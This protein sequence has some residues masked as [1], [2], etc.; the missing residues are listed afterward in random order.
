MKLFSRVVSTVLATVMVF[1]GLTITNVFAADTLSCGGWFESAYATWNDSNP[2]GASVAYKLAGSADYTNVDSELIRAYGST[3]R[4]DIP[5]LKGNT[6]YNL[7]ITSSDGNVIEKTVR[8][9][10]FRRDGFAHFNYT[11]GVGAYNDDGT[12]KSN[13]IVLYV[14]DENKDTVSVTSK[15]GTT[16]TGIGNILNSVGA[17]GVS[18]GTYNTNNYILRKLSMDGTPLDVRFIGKVTSP[19][20]LTEYDSVNNGGTEGDNGHMARMK[21][22]SNV[23]IEGIGYDATI[24]G[25]GFHYMCSSAYSQYGYGFEARNLNFQN[26]PEDALGMEGIQTGSQITA[27]VRRCWIHHNSFEAGYCAKPAESDKKEGDGSCDFKRGEYYTMEYCTYRNCH[28]TNLVGSSDSSMQ[29]HLTMANNHYIDCQARGPL[30]RQSDVHMYNNY[31]EGQTDYA[32]NPRANAFIFAEYNVFNRV[33]NACQVKSGGVCKSYNN[34]FISCS[35]NQQQTEVANKS[36]TVS[37]SSTY[38]N[39]DTNPSLSYIPNGNYKLLTDSKE[40]MAD[41]KAYAGTMK[42]NP[43]KAEEVNA[44]IIDSDYLPTAPVTV[45]Y[46]KAYNK[47]TITSTGKQTVDNIVINPT[48]VAPDSITI[49]DLGLVFTLNK[50][51]EVTMEG[52]QATAVPILYSEGG[53][54]Y[55]NTSGTAVLPAGTYVIQSSI[56][57]PGKKVYKEAKVVS[58]K[59]AVHDSSKDTTT[60]ESTTETTTSANVVSSGTYNIGTA[61]TGAND[62]IEKEANV[63]NIDY[64]LSDIVENSGTLK[65]SDDSAISFTVNGKTKFTPAF[66]GDNLT[67]TN[68]GS[69]TSVEV[70]AGGSVEIE[71]GTYSVTSKGTSNISS[72]TFDVSSVTTETTTET[73]TQTTTTTTTTETTTETTTAFPIVTVDLTQEAGVNP[74]GTAPNGKAEVIYQEASDDYLLNDTS[75]NCAATWTNSFEPISSGKVVV[76]G[77]AIPMKVSGKWAFVQIKGLDENGNV[78]DIADL[79]SDSQK[80]KNIALRTG[81][82]KYISSSNGIVANHKYEYE[83]IIDLDNQTVQ[84]TVDGTV[85]NG[86]ISAKSVNA[87]YNIT[88]TKD[89]DRN[90]VVSKPVVGVPYNGGETTTETSTESTTET[91]T[92][93]ST[94]TTTVTSTE[95]TTE[96]TTETTTESTTES[97]TET[98]TESTTES[99]T[100]VPTPDPS[101][102][103]KGDADGNGKVEADDAALVLQKVL[104]GAKV[105]IEDVATNAFELIDADNDGQLTAKDAA[106]ILQKAL[107][108]TFLM[109]NEK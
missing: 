33:K 39:F 67:I 23:T 53:K 36:D 83:F 13:A 34:F 82:S 76:R 97:T 107:D 49:K 65:N 75:S 93:T 103:V 6:D 20:G 52:M 98:T 48:K 41:V 64:A 85:L 47:T 87:V 11:D 55:I 51:A 108:S 88:A 63:A 27:P 104:T 106:Y 90:L 19:E 81:G 46:E 44:S 18:K 31:Y 15:D 24:D 21:D 62:C 7:K 26:Y 61:N 9:D 99:T 42:E 86:T 68:I 57:D 16:V 38:A 91:T 70:I 84:L 92:E 56:F 66:T 22:A 40:I 2:K 5:G 58:L 1:S 94:E 96:S 50:T 32:V 17:Q 59:F 74:V 72:L 29:F 8:T 73:T 35:G 60:S 43:V 95:T 109:P 4:V 25:W 89:T 45:P 71:K 30:A 54:E 101:K 10:A 102:P 69:G 77:Y 14:T 100:E 105:A 3:A 28:K 80:A 78:I 12:L 37:S 79:A